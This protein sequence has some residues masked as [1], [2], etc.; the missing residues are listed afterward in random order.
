MLNGIWT[1]AASETKK[2]HLSWEASVYKAKSLAR[3]LSWTRYLNL[4]AKLYFPIMCYGHGDT[5]R[6]GQSIP[7][8]EPEKI[9]QTHP[10]AFRGQKLYYS[11]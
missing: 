9:S 6:D 7:H 10:L 1:L 2:T 4:C 5:S 11:N 3:A 8:R